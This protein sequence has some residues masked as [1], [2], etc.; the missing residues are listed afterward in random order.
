[1]RWGS[2]FG[3][4]EAQLAEAARREREGGESD[5]TRSERAG[6]TLLDRLR[7]SEGGMVAVTLDAG[8]S[9]AGTLRKV[10]NGWLILDA[11]THD[12]LIPTDGILCLEG[13]SRRSAPEAA[14]VWQ[15]RGLGAALRMI[16]RDRSPVRVFLGY[17]GTCPAERLGVIAGVGADH[18]ELSVLDAT[19]ERPRGTVAIPFRGVLALRGEGVVGAFEGM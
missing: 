6:S 17:G 11:G 7:G 10:G 19:G 2:L 13:L 12:W 18:L 16:S 5:V 4:M 15:G 3:D 1:M 9:P 14:S 8:L